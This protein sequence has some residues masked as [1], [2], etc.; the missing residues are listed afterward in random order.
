[1][2]QRFA[3]MITP[4]DADEERADCSDSFT[5]VNPTAPALSVGELST[6]R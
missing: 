6:Q 3:L 1:M 5:A 2:A 4:V